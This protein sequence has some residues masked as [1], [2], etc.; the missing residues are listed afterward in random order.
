MSNMTDEI[1][2]IYEAVRTKRADVISPR[3]MELARQE[4]IASGTDEQVEAQLRGIVEAA[5][6]KTAEEFA[7]Y[8]RSEILSPRE[9]SAEEMEAAK[10]GV[11]DDMYNATAGADWDG[12]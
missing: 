2:A 11:G 10:G 9:L 4:G 5:Q 8:L 6:H 3:T 12:Q 7:S 1:Q